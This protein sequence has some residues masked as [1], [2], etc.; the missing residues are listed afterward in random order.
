MKE[1]L[2]GK[3]KMVS[4]N[5]RD[6]SFILSGEKLRNNSDEGG[7]ELSTTINC[8]TTNLEASILPEDCSPL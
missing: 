4:G 6:A 3:I 8:T 1:I 7:E 5:Y 2:K